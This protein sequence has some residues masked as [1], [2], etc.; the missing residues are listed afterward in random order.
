MK[1]II[2]IAMSFMALSTFSADNDHSYTCAFDGGTFVK[3]QKNGKKMFV[4]TA[5]SELKDKI[6]NIG[7][8]L[9]YPGLNTDATSASTSFST[10]KTTLYI[11][12]PLEN[13]EFKTIGK[14]LPSKYYNRDNVLEEG[15]CIKNY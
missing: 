10:E 8:S 14:V 12:E 3:I 9:Y 7:G 2:F 1:K 15:S 6:T 4:K 13:G 5:E 11:S